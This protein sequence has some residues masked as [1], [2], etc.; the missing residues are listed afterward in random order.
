MCYKACYIDSVMLKGERV[1]ENIYSDKYIKFQD[2]CDYIEKEG[3]SKIKRVI[4][5]LF[6]NGLVL[7]PAIFTKYSRDYRQYMKFWDNGSQILADIA[8]G[9]TLVGAGISTIVGD[10]LKDI[11]GKNSD[12]QEMYIKMQTAYFM[13]FYASFF[14]AIEEKL[15]IEGIDDLF[16][17]FVNGINIGQEMY[18]DL[19]NG[20]GINICF[21]S[22]EN[23]KE[24][25]IELT[26][27]FEK[28]FFALDNIRLLVEESKEQ[29]SYFV[30]RIRC[31]PDIAIKKYTH[32][33]AQLVMEYPKFQSWL[34]VKFHTELKEQFVDLPNAIAEHV[35]ENIID[36]Y[37][38][39]QTLKKELYSRFNEKFFY[40]FGDEQCEVEDVFT[41]NHYTFTE[42]CGSEVKQKVKSIHEIM[43]IHKQQRKKESE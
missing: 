15:V 5:H 14:E 3:N 22:T 23:I 21:N 20:G 42:L 18:L 33:I 11:F 29:K 1:V 40:L 2:I 9:A 17:Q 34:S 12:Y 28:S 25:Y 41:L 43:N 4:K 7:L 13:C 24:G 35:S 26:N 8:T 19:E 38:K 27:N 37:E 39:K 30:E 31:L 16:S 32:Q 36:N 6:A 10:A